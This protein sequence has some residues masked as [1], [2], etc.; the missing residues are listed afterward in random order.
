MK[1]DREETQ[2]I[3][4]NPNYEIS[5]LTDSQSTQLVLKLNPIYKG[6]TNTGKDRLKLL[7][8]VRHHMQSIVSV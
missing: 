1:I 8:D 6:I 5:E 2:K 7:E 4:A 3:F